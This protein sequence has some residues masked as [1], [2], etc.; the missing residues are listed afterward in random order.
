MLKFDQ[1]RY[2]L[3]PYIY[4]LAGDVTQGGG[5][6]M[7]AFVMDFRN[8][9]KAREIDDQYMFGPS[10]MVSPVTQYKSRS[11]SVYLPQSA[12]WY[13]W[14]TGKMFTGGQTIVAPAPYESMPLYVKAGSLIPVGPELQYTAEHPADPITLYVYAGADGAFT[15][16]EDEGVNY[17]YEKGQFTRI[18]LHWD[19]AIHTLTIGKRQGSFPGMLTQRT[20]AV[21]LISKTKPIGF[22]FTP[23]VD[24]TIH[25]DGKELKIGL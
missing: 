13:D 14:W 21:V 24:R 22:S 19:D 10:L 25:Y 16:Y 12:G 7:R 3:L 20:F 17:D 18:L 6:I 11:R 9:A 2:R 23:R 1:L 5:S 8:D 15:L 4:S